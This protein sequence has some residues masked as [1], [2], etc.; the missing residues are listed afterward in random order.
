MNSVAAEPTN[1][2]A[3]TVGR[4]IVAL[5]DKNAFD[6]TVKRFNADMAA[7][8]PAAQLKQAWDAVGQQFGAFKEVRSVRIEKKDEYRIALLLCAFEKADL[9]VTVSVDPKNQVGG[10]FFRPAGNPSNAGPPWSPPSYAAKVEEQS[11]VVGDDF[12][13]PATL[14]VPAGDGP[15]PVVI[16]VHGSGPNDRDETLGANKPFKDLA[17]GLAAKGIA[18][19]RYDK[20]TLKYPGQFPSTKPYGLKEEIIDD[21]KAAVSLVLKTPKLDGKRVVVAGHSLGGTFGPRI[22]E[23]EPRVKALVLL[24]GATR[25]MDVLVREQIKVT[26]PGNAAASAAAEAFSKKFNDPKLTAAEEVDFLGA[27]LPGSYVLELRNEQPATR[28]AKLKLP[29]FIGQGGRD[30]QVTTTDLDGWKK[31]L[32]KKPN[33]TI[34]LWPA[35]NHA[36]IEGTGPSTPQEYAVPG[37]VAEVVVTDLAAWINKLPVK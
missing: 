23:E 20:R 4:E 27:K 15:F 36:L 25:P 12:K 9:L 32:E 17:Y 35:L 16:L 28:A 34:K 14:I 33:V 10:L 31:T 30:Y 3:E 11:V 29:I 22:A 6:D 5:L 24:A 7:A 1:A 18:T 37:H 19:L 13:L 2:E 21:V 26:A 8:L